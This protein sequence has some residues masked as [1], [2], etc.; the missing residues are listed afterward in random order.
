MVIFAPEAYD[1][2]CGSWQQVRQEP[3]IVLRLLNALS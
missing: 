3:G 2:Y 1:W